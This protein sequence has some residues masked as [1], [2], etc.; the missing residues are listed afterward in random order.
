MKIQSIIIIAMLFAANFASAG[1]VPKNYALFSAGYTKMLSTGDWGAQGQG[2]QDNGFSATEYN[3]GQSYSFGYG[4][5]GTLFGIRG[6]SEFQLHVLSPKDSFATYTWDENSQAAQNTCGATYPQGCPTQVV[7]H[8][9]K[10]KAISATALPEWAPFESGPTGYLRLGVAFEDC[11]F[12]YTGWDELTGGRSFSFHTEGR[13]K[14]ARGVYGLGGHWGH[15]GLDYTVFNQMTANVG[16]NKDKGNY[17]GATVA[18]IYYR[19]EF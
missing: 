2:S 17:R 8:R 1:E 13:T 11:K 9:Q 10:C 19:G 14:A 3:H 18:S 6:A 4:R 15:W 7:Y 16:E 12:E 5:R